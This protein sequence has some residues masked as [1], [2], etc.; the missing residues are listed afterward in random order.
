M[1]VNRELSLLGLA[2]KAGRLA[3]GG[4][5]VE[6]AIRQGRA[7][8]VITASDAADNT[9]RRLRNRSGGVPVA[10]LPYTKETLGAAIGY[11]SCAAAAICD[12]GFVQAF[13]RARDLSNGGPPRESCDTVEDSTEINI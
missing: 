3:V 13:G 9:V 1:P 5:A 8:L 6:A 10:P 7:K 2:M 4:E 11:R 12:D